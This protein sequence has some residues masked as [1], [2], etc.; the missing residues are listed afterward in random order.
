MFDMAQFNRF[1]HKLNS[2]LKQN[3]QKQT[4][5]IQNGIQGACS[6]K[7]GLFFNSGLSENLD[8]ISIF[9]LKG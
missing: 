4:N 5:N 7:S 6:Q 1:N 3:R 2:S 9:G 8:F